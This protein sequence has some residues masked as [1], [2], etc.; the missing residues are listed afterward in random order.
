MKTTAESYCKLMFDILKNCQTIF[1]SDYVI[2]HSYQQC[3]EVPISPHLVQH[4]LKL[5]ILVGVTVSHCGFD[6]HLPND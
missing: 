5:S 3:R 4:L 2:L 6:L 1:P